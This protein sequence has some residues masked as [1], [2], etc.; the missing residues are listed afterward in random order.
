MRINFVMTGFG[1]TRGTA[2]HE[3]AFGYAD[4]LLARGHDVSIVTTM[5]TERPGWY[6]LRTPVRQPSRVSPAVAAARTALSYAGYRLGRVDR[7]AVKGSLSALTAELAP[8]SA[9]PYRRASEL[10][11]M[12]LAA[13]PADVTIATGAPTA[14]PVHL[15]GTGTKA[16][17]MQHYEPYFTTES[18]P[19]W[20]RCYELEA[21][22]SYRLPLHRIANS[23]WLAEHV[24]E[25]HGGE[26][27]LCV[28]ALEHT[29]FY[30]DGSPPPQPLTVVSYSGRGAAWKGFAEAAEAIR[31]VRE[32]LG[33][34]RWLV[35]G[36]D[37]ALAPDNPIAPYESLG[38]VDA[39]AIRRLY[40]R[41]HVA[42]CPA[43][44][45]SFAMYPI[46][47]MACGCAVVTTP[48]GVED[49][50][51]DGRNALIA[52]ARD[53]R[54]MADAVVRLAED[55][56]LRAH[57]VDQGLR[58]VRPFTWERSLDRMEELL[59]ALRERDHDAGQA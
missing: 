14:L 38:V 55:A 39:A 8:Y 31:L 32:R 52:P 24:H 1:R 54:A 27:H 17:L 9:F 16:Y 18:D 33:E 25:R 6:D 13:P 34:V 30:P 28:N 46:E 3:I 37:A 29:R 12:R 36:A 56:E 40:S 22:F 48:N 51:R 19:Q 23:T 45:E 44:Y 50:A 4:G 57:L 43:W 21:E 10:E 49:Y 26:V 7:D 15:F 11:R 35:F 5:P 59:G 47:A 41:A 2:G 58:D 53:S 20:Q 42:L